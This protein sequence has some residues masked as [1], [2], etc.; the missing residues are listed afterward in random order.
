MPQTK[1]SWQS[2]PL[3]SPLTLLADRLRVDLLEQPHGE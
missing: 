1:D 3:K 2:F